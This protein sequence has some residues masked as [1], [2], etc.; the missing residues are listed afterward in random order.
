MTELH[1]A[2][3]NQSGLAVALRELARTLAARGGFA[4]DLDVEGW[5]RDL[6]TAADP[7]LF[8]SARELLTNVVKH[9]GATQVQVRLTRSEGTARLSVVDDGRG[10][11]PGALAQRLA[12][13]HIGLASQRARL[14]A[15]GGR[16]HLEPGPAGGTSAVVDVPISE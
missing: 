16:L 11:A 4:V 9:A 10:I 13:G 6:R 5:P 8:A 2:V 3:L 7:V 1:P 15:V 12:E 14:D